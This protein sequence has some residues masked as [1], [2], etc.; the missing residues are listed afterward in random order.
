MGQVFGMLQYR[1]LVFQKKQE[2]SIN[3]MSAVRVF[4]LGNVYEYQSC[5]QAWAELAT[6]HLVE[7]LNSVRNPILDFALAIWKEAPGTGEIGTNTLLAMEPTRVTQIFN[8]TV[9]GGSANLVGTFNASSIEF[10]IG[11][12]DFSSLERVLIENGVAQED[13]LELKVALDSESCVNRI[14]GLQ[15]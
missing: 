10:N 2:C 9:Y 15:R 12:K 6:G 1:L 5:R 8:T 11:P 4:P 3:V 14:H 7:L 13:V